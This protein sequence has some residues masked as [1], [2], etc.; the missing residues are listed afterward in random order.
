MQECI[1]KL[2]VTAEQGIELMRK[3]KD[4]MEIG[5]VNDFCPAFIHPDL[6]VYR[7]TVR[8]VTVPAGTVVEF[9]VPA[10]RTL[11]NVDPQFPGLAGK[12]GHGSFLLYKRG[13]GSLAQEILIGVFPDTSDLQVTH[14]ASLPSFQ[15][16]L[17]QLKGSLPKG[18][19]KQ[20]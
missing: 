2:L 13:T 18:G 1:E 20:G 3:G 17:V 16:D 9:K 6:L 15:T 19:H 10:V 8:A 11:G 14:P 7:L 5:R 4:H 12:D